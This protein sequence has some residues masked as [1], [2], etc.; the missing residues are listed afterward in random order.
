MATVSFLYRG[1]LKDGT[2]FDNGGDESHTIVLG[3]SQVMPALE[4]I[5]GQMQVGEE[6]TVDIN[7]KDAYG[8]YSEDA[9]V[10]VPV[11][12]I[13]NGDK[14]PAGK[15]ILWQSPRSPNPIP[16]KI[17]SIVNQVAELDFNHPLAGKDIRYWV[18]VVDRQD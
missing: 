15:M 1:S 3:R 16:A 14:M 11:Y 13:P 7:A 17:K 2:V 8:A 5:M 4:Q 12:K 10:R 18:K 6:R 9:V